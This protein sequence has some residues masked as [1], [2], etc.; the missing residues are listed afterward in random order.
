MTHRE[1][2]VQ[3]DT[4]VVGSGP[5]GATFARRLV[6]GGRS[7]LMVDAGAK[8]SSRP[9]AHLKN[10][11]LY[12]RNLDLFSSVIRGHLQPLSVASND[13]PVVTLDP[14][15]FQ[16]DFSKYEGFVHNNQNPDQDPARHLPAAAVTYGVGGMATHWTCATPRQHPRVH[17]GGLR[18]SRRVQEIQQKGSR[19]ARHLHRYAAGPDEL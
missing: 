1:D 11:F 4:L 7:V 12:Q 5:I 6:E 3:V 16:V 2:T 14:A 19:G 10:A 9:G 13:Q 15:A 18:V 8:Q 17:S